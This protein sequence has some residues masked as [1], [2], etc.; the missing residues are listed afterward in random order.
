MTEDSRG[1]FE[2]IATDHSAFE[3]D[4]G[5]FRIT[6]TVFEATVTVESP[7]DREGLHDDRQPGAVPFENVGDDD[8]SLDRDSLD[9]EMV[10]R[11]A[12]DR[13]SAGSAQ[14]GRT[15]IDREPDDP[16][17]DDS[18]SYRV[19]IR[20]PTLDDVVVGERVATVVEDGWYETFTLRL[21][22]AEQATQVVDVLDISAERSTETV[23]VD[24]RAVAPPT[25]ATIEDLRALVEY[26][27][28]TWVEG[29]IPGYDYR[30]PA[31]TLLDRARHR[32]EHD[33]ES[34]GTDH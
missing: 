32:G 4:N 16:E 6:T 20:T 23:T 1:P 9:R 31:A 12:L 18:L 25:E 30:E 34:T 13:D 28:G 27:E 19:T 33:S 2:S 10:D 29:M 22:D 26:V 5:R 11:D 3:P 24:I 14:G 8:D 21:E 17:P 15:P 7:S